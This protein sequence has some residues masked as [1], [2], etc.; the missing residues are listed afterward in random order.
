MYKIFEYFIFDFSACESDRY[1]YACKNVCGSCLHKREEW[2]NKVTGVCNDGCNNIRG[3]Y[4][5]PLC[6]ISYN[7]FYDTQHVFYMFML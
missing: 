3:I 1:G 5:P 2:C 7:L 6:Q 4:I